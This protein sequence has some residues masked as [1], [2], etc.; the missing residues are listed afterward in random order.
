MQFSTR[1]LSEIFLIKF[2]KKLIVAFANR[3]AMLVRAKAY[4][5]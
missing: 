3:V 5:A 2:M 4:D 1:Y